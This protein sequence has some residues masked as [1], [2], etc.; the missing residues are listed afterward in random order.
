[1]SLVVGGALANKAGNGGEAWVRLSWIRGFQQLGL[2]VWFVEELTSD[3]CVDAAGRRVVPDEAVCVRFFRDVVQ[4][5][6]LESRASL[7]VDGVPIV[8]PA[9]ADLG[10]LASQSTLVNISG[11]LAHPDL[12]RAFRRRALVDI[13]PG[14]TQIWHAQGMPGAR[15]DDHDMHFT[16][17]ENIGTPGC[18]IPTGG[19][20]WRPVRQPVV[21]DDWPACEP[22]PERDRFTTVSSWRGPFGP[23]EHEGRRYGLKL[24]EFRKLVAIPEMSPHTFEIAVNIDP[25]DGRDL[26]TLHHH[27][28]RTV[29]PARVAGAPE[30]FRSYV[31]GSGGEFSAAHG[32]YVDT[33]SGWISD[34]TVR[35]L[36]SGRPAI[37]QDTGF[38][39][40]LPAGDGLLPF[41]TLDGAVEAVNRV[42]GAYEHHAAAA[43]ALAEE[44]FA[45]EHVLAR[46]CDEAGIDV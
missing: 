18:P 42:V 35:Y 6:G 3:Q 41:R 29:D 45:A 17:G 31:Q 33:A 11:H 22:P 43:R 39:R 26:A 19:V 40:R 21:L 10:D 37:V 2:D 32:V 15:V 34:R 13:D 12:F 28:W 30:T 20:R 4:R 38:G 8:G 16:I 27:G 25:A 24:H 23:V 36:T 1:M 46:F 7:L 5:F 9:L 14:F 44:H